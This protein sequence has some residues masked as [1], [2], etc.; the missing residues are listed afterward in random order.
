MDCKVTDSAG[1]GIQV[2]TELTAASGILLDGNQVIRAG[3]D[4]IACTKL[5]S[6]CTLQYNVT[7]E[8]HFDGIDINALSD[9]HTLFK[10][11][12]YQ[13][14]NMGLELGG[15]G[16]TV[17][18]N[19][20]KQSSSSGIYVEG[21][22]NGGLYTKNKVKFSGSHGLYVWGTG[23]NFTQ[24]KLTFNFGFDRFSAVALAANAWVANQYNTSNL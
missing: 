9:G 5:A 1:V 3:A 11:K 7:R 15:D 22:S 13:S 12:V 24:N 20:A 23:N 16:C 10:N 6:N 2:G 17:T 18:Q 21:A 19:K 4:A 8:A 14:G